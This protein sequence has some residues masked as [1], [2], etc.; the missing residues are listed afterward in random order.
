MRAIRVHELGDPEVLTLDE[1]DVPEPGPREVRVRI[2]AAG[3]NFIDTYHRDGKYPLDLPATIGVEAGG[4]VEAVGPDVEGLTEGDRVAYTGQRG[5]YAEQQVVP[6]DAVVEIPDELET[7]RAVAVLLQGMTAHYLT[8]DTFPV[9]DGD[10]ALVHAAAGGVGH[11]LTQIC[12]HLGARVI[13]TCGTEEKAKLV[14]D[15]G[16]DEVVIYTQEDFVEAVGEFTQG[17]GVDVVYDGVGQ[18][19]F[20]DGLGCIRRRGT[21][22]LYGQASGPVEPLDPQQLNQHGSL[23][24]TRPSLFDY[25]AERDE[26]TRRSTDLFGWLV[27]DEIE[28]RVDRVFDLEDAA[29]AHRYLEGRNTHGKVLLT[30]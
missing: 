6:A 23:F 28:V 9:G 22:V 10:T 13:A 20:Q 12:K 18:A 17:R 14:R 4:T 11:L 5:A 29:E 24:L 8:H 3:L 19:T 7:N 30:P 15:F 25:V 16:A 21:M 27:D 2:E 26:L 1:V